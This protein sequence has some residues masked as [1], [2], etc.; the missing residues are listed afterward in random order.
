MET[1]GEMRA[2][3]DPFPEM[4][5]EQDYSERPEAQGFPVPPPSTGSPE[6]E[7]AASTPLG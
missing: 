2:A 7:P 1:E 4:G 3:N 5:S 6:L